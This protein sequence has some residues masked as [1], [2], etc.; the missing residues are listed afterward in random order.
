[1]ARNRVEI[2]EAKQ[3]LERMKFEIASELGFSDYAHMNK[4]NLTARENGQVGGQMVKKLIQMAEAN[5][6]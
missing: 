1:M 4:A 5:L 6:K 2:P 3:A